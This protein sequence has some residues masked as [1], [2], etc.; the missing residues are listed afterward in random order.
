MPTEDLCRVYTNVRLKR[1]YEMNVATKTDP[2]GR[3]KEDL[4]QESTTRPLPIPPCFP[5]SRETLRLSSSQMN[6]ADS[7]LEGLIYQW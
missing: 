7:Q 4:H 1:K 2:G 5:P 6:D 3:G